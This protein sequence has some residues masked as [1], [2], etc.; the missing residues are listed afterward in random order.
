MAECVGE[1]V[2]EERG[3]KESG[4]VFNGLSYVGV[5]SGKKKEAALPSARSQE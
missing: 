1:M 5:G 3:G 4:V 2:G